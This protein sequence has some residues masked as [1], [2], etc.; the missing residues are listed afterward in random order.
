MCSHWGVYLPLSFNYKEVGSESVG[1]GRNFT[2]N[3]AL[4]KLSGEH[5]QFQC[6]EAQS[7]ERKTFSQCEP[8]FPNCREREGFYQKCSNEGSQVLFGCQGT[9]E[10]AVFLF[11]PVRSSF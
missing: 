6:G 10:S 7:S 1:A 5:L 8:A 4:L 2:S 11:H 9:T 3:V